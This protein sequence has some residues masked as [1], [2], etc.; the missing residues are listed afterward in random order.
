MLAVSGDVTLPGFSTDPCDMK[1]KVDAKYKSGTLTDLL[2]FVQLITEDSD[3]LAQAGYCSRH[4]SNRP[5]TGLIQINSSNI[6]TNA[7]EIENFVDILMHEIIHILV[8][9]P[10]H[11]EFLKGGNV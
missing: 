1:L 11:Y 3:L 7:S 8:F 10:S 9:S 6:N 4:S 5:N 2:I